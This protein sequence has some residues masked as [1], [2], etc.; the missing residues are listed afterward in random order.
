MNG[1][2][3]VAT[4]SVPSADA[5][6]PARLASIPSTHFSAKIFAVFASSAIDCI[7]RKL[8]TP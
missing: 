4:A 2:S 5:S 8:C 3:A 1:L 6:Q 7:A